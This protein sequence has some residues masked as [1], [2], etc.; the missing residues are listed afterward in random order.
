[1]TTMTQTAYHIENRVSGQSLGIFLAADAESA[2]VAMD[3]AAGYEPDDLEPEWVAARDELRVREIDVSDESLQALR[4]EAGQA[5]DLE[6]VAIC[7]DALLGDPDA[8]VAC[9]DVIYDAICAAA[10]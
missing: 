10:G 1:M 6:M 8:I 5:G 2:L 4:T 9:A 3:R 7:D